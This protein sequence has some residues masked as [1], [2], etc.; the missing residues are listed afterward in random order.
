MTREE[1]ID[2]A[3]RCAAA[4][5]VHPTEIL[6]EWEHRLSRTPDYRDRVAEI[7]RRQWRE[8]GARERRFRKYEN[9]EKVDIVEL[10]RARPPMWRKAR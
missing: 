3:V 7:I 6:H 10:M 1:T 4:V 8:F 9:P 5:Y 2:R